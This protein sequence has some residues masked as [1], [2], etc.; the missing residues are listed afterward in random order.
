MSQQVLNDL[1]ES[2]TS[3]ISMP[4]LTAWS[5]PAGAEIAFHF[6]FVLLHH[7][8]TMLREASD[9]TVAAKEAEVHLAKDSRTEDPSSCTTGPETSGDQCRKDSEPAA[10]PAQPLTGIPTLV[11]VRLH[12]PKAK[13]KCRHHVLKGCLSSLS[14]TS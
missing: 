2:V 9:E 8:L 1:Y 5:M 6:S 3:Q 10:D 7:S 11:T 14:S 4:R 13:P 12:P